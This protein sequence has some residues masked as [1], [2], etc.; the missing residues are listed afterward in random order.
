MHIYKRIFTVEAPLLHISRRRSVKRFSRY[1]RRPVGTLDW[2]PPLFQTSTWNL[3]AEVSSRFETEHAWQGLRVANETFQ[4]FI[5]LFETISC[6]SWFLFIFLNSFSSNS[7][8]RMRVP[9]CINVILLFPLPFSCKHFFHF[10]SPFYK[11]F[12]LLS[13]ERISDADPTRQKV[14]GDVFNFPLQK[15][16]FFFFNTCRSHFFIQ[17]STASL[18]RLVEMRLLAS[19]NI[20]VKRS[21]NGWKAFLGDPAISIWITRFV[22]GTNPFERSS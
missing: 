3:P 4:P 9:F 2:P 5:L 13:C 10:F 6:F 1:T 11:L 14:T 22:F 12:F 8:T 16:F 7:P 21:I 19:S 18:L 15:C 17:L 20:L